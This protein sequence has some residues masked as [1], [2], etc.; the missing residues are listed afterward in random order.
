MQ[1]M[2]DLE[3]HKTALKVLIPDNYE[4]LISTNSEG[5]MDLLNS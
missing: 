3:E 4:C 5:P 2:L 1:Q